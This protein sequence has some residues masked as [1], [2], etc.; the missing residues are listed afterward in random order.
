MSALVVTVPDSLGGVRVDRVVALLAD[1]PR[2]A[3]DT[4]VDEGRITVDGRVVRRRSVLVRAGQELCVERPEKSPEAGPGPDESVEFTVV[5]ADDQV[6]VVDKPAGLV[7]HPGA[8]HSGGTL[9]NGLLSR[10][11]ELASVAEET[12]SD[13]AGRE[14]CTGSTAGL[15]VCW[16]WPGPRTPIG[17]SSSS[18]SL[19]S[20]SRSY[21]AMVWG[22][23][24]GG[25]GVVEAPIGRSTAVPT[26]MAVSRTGKPAAH[27]LPGGATLRRAADHRAVGRARNR[28]NPSD[29]GPPCCGR[30]S[31]GGRPGLRTWGTGA[32]GATGSA[33]PSCRPAHV[34]GSGFGSGPYVR[35]ASTGGSRRSP[36]A[37]ES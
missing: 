13:P 37:L 18:S 27:P 35:F 12:G 21:A 5:E 32:T 33:L 17:R 14:S 36:P 1:L 3:V 30:P 6:I 7:V 4:L 23:V 31:G 26:R 25:S 11:P 22:S 8:G 29:P 16:W 19:D 10:F 15:R 20:V 28:E 9:V 24:E 34:R 2:T